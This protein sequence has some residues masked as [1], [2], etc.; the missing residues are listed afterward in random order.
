VPQTTIKPT[1]YSLLILLNA[2]S[3]E[4]Y[5]QRH[6]RKQIHGFLNSKLF[7]YRKPRLISAPV[8]ISDCQTCACGFE[9][10][11]QFAATKYTLPATFTY[12][13]AQ[14]ANRRTKSRGAATRRPANVPVILRLTSSAMALKAAETRTATTAKEARYGYVASVEPQTI[15]SRSAGA[16]NMPSVLFVET[17]LGCRSEICGGG[18]LPGTYGPVRAVEMCVLAASRA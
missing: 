6:Q 14:T 4:T 1:R 5:S 12:C 10:N 18:M 16:V 11:T 8:F 15:G 2:P 9:T 7:K 13:D 17:S 3:L